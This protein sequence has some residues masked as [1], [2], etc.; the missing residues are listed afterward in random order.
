MLVFPKD[1][2]SFWKF[3]YRASPLTYFIDGLVSS[4][5]ANVP[6]TCSAAEALQFN[7][8]HGSN[9]NNCTEYLTPYIHQ[10]GGTLLN[11]STQTR[12]DYCPI[13]NTS[14]LLNGIGISTQS[15]WDNIGYLTVFIAFN[16]FA[17][18]CFYWLA[19]CPRK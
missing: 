17:T 8:P 10:F 6:V 19:R 14:A 18:Y 12:C 1:I 13:S 2:P 7:V 16:I 5:L 9:F 15:P 11:S 3:V 4:G